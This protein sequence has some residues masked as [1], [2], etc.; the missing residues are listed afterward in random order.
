M[1][2]ART[3]LRIAA[4]RALRGATIAE[5]RVFDSRIGEIDFTEAT[6]RLPLVI[7]TTDDEEITQIE[8]LDI[9]GAPSVLDLV[10][11]MSIATTITLENG[12]NDVAVG[13]TDATLELALDI[14]ARQVIRTLQTS[15]T[16]WADLFRRLCL[17]VETL[18]ARRGADA[19]EGVRFAA[20]QIVMQA[21]PLSDPLYTPVAGTPI[22]DFLVLCD[23][24]PDLA[25]VAAAFRSQLSASPGSPQADRA[26]LGLSAD[27]ADRIGLDIPGPQPPPSPT[28]WIDGQAAAGGGAAL[29]PEA[30]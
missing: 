27:T 6:E 3:A 25:P 30:P 17:K 11:D 13:Q 20:R 4:C 2:L 9:I 15:T 8:G 18:T 14:L 19:R 5:N 7:V 21:M 22:A 10:F 26:M 16:P 23:Q 1:S 12:D 28:L 29:V 24:T